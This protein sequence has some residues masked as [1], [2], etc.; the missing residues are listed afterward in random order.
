MKNE[1]APLFDELMKSY[2]GVAGTP[3]LSNTA[4]VEALLTDYYGRPYKRKSKTPAPAVSLS[5]SQDNGEVLPQPIAEDRFEEYVVQKSAPVQ[6]FEEYTVSN[7]C[8]STG[9]AIASSLNIG[10]VDAVSANQECQVDVLEP[11]QTQ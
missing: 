6:G 7:G 8:R 4:K 5:L 2:Y 1:T 10:P 11:L 9:R 3:E